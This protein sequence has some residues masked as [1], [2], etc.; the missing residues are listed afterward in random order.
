MP[1]ELLPDADR[2][3]LV[4]AEPLGWVLS[5]NGSQATVRLQAPERAQRSDGARVTVGKFL[6]IRTQQSLAIGVLTKIAAETDA[7]GVP[8]G[9]HATG[10]LDL[11]GEIRTDDSGVARFDRGVK[12]YPTIGDPADL[13]GHEEL[14]AV[15]GGCGPDTI[16]IGHLQQDRSI[17]A[18]VKIDDMVR[19]HFAVF[20]TTGVGKSSGVALILQ[21]ILE[22]RPHL[23]IFLIDPHN[24][25]SRCFGNRAQIL[26]PKNLKLPFWLFNFEETI[27]V[28][29]R[30]RP[31]VEEEVEI[32]SELIPLA[33][34]NVAHSRGTADRPSIRKL[35]P[36]SNGYTLD[37]PVPYRF[38][39]LIGLIDER[40]GKLENRSAWSKYHRLLT[41]IET[42]RN[43]PRYAF[44]FENA[45]IGGDT[46][47]EVL[48]QL[49][50]LP[51]N[52]RPMTIMQLAGFPAEVVDCVVSVV[53]RMAFEFG[54]WSDGAS[55]LLIA[56]EE[57]HRY[58]PADRTIGFGPTRKAISRIAK[59]GRKYG[60]YL[61]LM[62]QRPA[63]LDATIISQ[64]STLFAMRMA[65]DRDQNIVRAAVSDAAGSLLGFLPSLG[66]REV[67]AFGEGVP[68][69]TRLRFKEL[70]PDRIPRSEAVGR[71]PME[72]AQA[73]DADFIASVVERWRGAM[74]S[75]RGKPEDPTAEFDTLATEEFSLVRQPGPRVP[76]RP[77][78]PPNGVAA[79]PDS[80]FFPV[81]DNPNR[82][83]PRLRKP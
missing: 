22:A 59:E 36:R 74:V 35:N 78:P 72:S 33:K 48:S 3:S 53:C 16:D 27:D 6:G 24:E 73:M 65:S 79:R 14:E 45:N 34:G 60:I 2:P 26:N 4:P 62:T 37:T 57:A 76:E 40:M 46:M 82:P 25:Y 66:A 38:D 10:Q 64:C 21:Q 17:G 47:V 58:A 56:C 15:F 32:L 31:G 5:V 30:G 71:A 41:R 61:G 67:F 55:P 7:M 28:F 77:L 8:H 50:R 1:T 49:F 83:G 63:D 52:G 29:F 68:V 80:Y 20:G 23:R 81:E 19:K 42:A 75:S 18:Y 54:L 13:I 11:L 9:E 44:M 12:E 69:P 70:P 39:D 51:A 43:D